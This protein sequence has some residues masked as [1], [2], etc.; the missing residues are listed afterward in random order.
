MTEAKPQKKAEERLKHGPAERQRR[1][2]A[3]SPLRG[4]ISLKAELVVMT[5]ILVLAMSGTMGLTVAWIYSRHLESG[6]VESAAAF[7][8]GAALNLSL[9][10]DWNSYP[11][12]ALARISEET[13]FSLFQVVDNRGRVI[14]RHPDKA[15]AREE[16][17]L[18]TALLNGQLEVGFDGSAFSVAVPVLRYGQP[19]GA[20]V[21]SGYPPAMPAANLAAG[22]WML[23]ALGINL[24]L[25][26]F[27][28]VFFLN[29][30]LAAPVG[31]LARDLEALGQNRFQP[32]LRPGASREIAKLF[33]AFDQAALELMESRRR[34]EE[35]LLTI[36]RAQGSLVAS[37]KMA[38]VGRLASGLAHE[39]G[40][41][42]GALTGFVHLLGQSNLSPEDK[43]LILTQSAH[44]LKRMDG[45]IKELLHFSRPSRREPEPVDAAAVAAAAISLARPQ[46][47][48]AGVEM[49][50][51][52]EEND[53]PPV[54]AERNGL[55]QVLLNLLSNAGQALAGR[56][57]P[58]VLISLHR[59]GPDGWTRLTV[60]DNGPGVDPGDEPVLFEPYFTRKEPGQGTGLGL[61][62]SRSIINGFG[63]RLEYFPAEAGGA[64][65]TITLPTARREE[66]SEDD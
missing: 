38:T 8:R 63:G 62:V 48:A 9:E 50:F 39:L 42:I 55:L 2:V 34:L 6:Q 40:N 4:F 59:A 14:Y 31:E 18:R 33:L 58:T 27:F 1:K 25:M 26:I 43:A 3:A 54:L 17:T 49:V 28:L 22:R 45:S 61:A 13:G 10:R 44:E 20:L 64:V 46:K 57:A 21:F 32:R 41:P 36:S 60:A 35:Q 56:A 53:P 24:I 16:T 23:A 52:A 37:E 51:H 66:G 5:T 65:F 47:W 19:A 11:W 7:A 15:G 29:R 30:R 12:A